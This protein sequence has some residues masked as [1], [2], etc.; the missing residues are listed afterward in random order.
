MRII[1]VNV[2][3]SVEAEWAGS[4]GRT[5]IDKRA[6]ASRV[7]V[8]VNGVAGDE[9]AD[10][11]HHGALDH[12]V[13]VYAREDYDWWEAELGRSLRDGQFGENLTTSGFDVNDAVVGDRWRVGSA[14]LEVSGPRIPCA[15]FRGWMGEQGWLKR[16]TRAARP[17]V[18]LRVVELGEL[19]AGDAVEV[20]SRAGA[21]VTVLDWF[22]ARH[23]DRDALRRILEV[24]GHGAEWD[25]LAGRLLR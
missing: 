14:L 8:L 5:A 7:A 22:R 6:V 4:A 11:K 16:F 18:Y 19:G 1:S 12:A 10:R 2:G 17:G 24:P 13:Y 15:V 9:R 20:V 21:G 3:R 23:G 25:E